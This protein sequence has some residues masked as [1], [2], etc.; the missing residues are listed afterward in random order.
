MPYIDDGY[1]GQIWTDEEIP[2]SAFEEALGREWTD[3]DDERLRAGESFVPQSAIDVYQAQG[4]QWPGATPPPTGTSVAPTD[5]TGDG[6]GGSGG[7]STGGTFDMGPLLQPYPGAFQK[8]AFGVAAKQLMDLIGPAPQF[9]P[10]DI[11]T[12]DPYA[13]TTADHVFADP[14]YGFRKDIGEKALLNNRAAQ[15]LARSGGTLKDLLDYN[16]NFASQ[17][18]SNVDTRRFR[19][20]SSNADTTLRRSGMEQDRAR[21]IFEPQLFEWNKKGDLS[22]RAEEGAYDN[23]FDEFLQDYR[24]FTDHRDSV[25]DK[26]KWSSEFGLDAATR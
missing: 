11:P 20:W 14:S 16:Q 9:A 12:I 4:A 22:V 1:G 2:L 17:E 15:G 5:T 10:P 13:P 23:A 18:F 25:F 21:S 26:L 6:D 8:P 24:M 7:G 3:E 19:D